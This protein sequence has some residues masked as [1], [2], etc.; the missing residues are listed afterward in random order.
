MYTTGCDDQRNKIGPG[1]MLET[2]RTLYPNR[3]DLPSETEIRQGI[4]AITAKYKK[5]GTI[6][7]KRGIQDPFKTVLSNIVQESIYTIKPRDAIDIF[8]ARTIEYANRD[9]YPSEAKVKSFV[10]ALK[11]KY[12]PSLNST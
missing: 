5:H 4:A 6:H 11:S 7:I 10:S 9:D 3:L 8:K 2:L 1:R 12:K